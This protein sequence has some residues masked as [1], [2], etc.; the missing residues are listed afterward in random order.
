MACLLLLMSALLLL[1]ASPAAAAQGTGTFNAPLTDA[2]LVGGSAV[3]PDRGHSTDTDDREDPEPLDTV[4]NCKGLNNVDCMMR[5]GQAGVACS[6]VLKH[7]YKEAGGK[8]DL[9]MCKT[10][11]PTKTCSYYYTNGDECVVFPPLTR[12][13]L[14]LYIG[15]RP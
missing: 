11:F 2:A 5:C 13:A 3:E 7:P 1:V 4:I 14:C 15:A 10:G 6:P 8:G 12:P 9:Y